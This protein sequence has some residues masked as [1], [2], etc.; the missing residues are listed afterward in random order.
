MLKSR[1]LPSAVV[2]LGLAAG[3]AWGGD[4]S[5]TWVAEFTT[6]SG[7]TRESTFN[8]EVDGEKL[9]GT[10]SGRRG[11]TPI[12]DGKISGEKITFSVTRDFGRGD[13]KFLYEGALSGDEIQM[14]VTIEGRDRT[15][16][17]TAKRAA[18]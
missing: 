4:V 18:E 17:M 1:I 2:V 9:T 11:D 8:F 5:G 3:V 7:Q 13:M 6:P 15:F 16:D 10:V 12:E 14:K